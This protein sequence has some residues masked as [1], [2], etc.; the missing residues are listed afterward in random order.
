MTTDT[1]NVTTTAHSTLEPA[2]VNVRITISALWAA[3]LFVFAYVDIFSFLRSDYRADVEAG[4]AGAFSIDQTFLLL[5]TVYV[6]VPA[7]MVVAVLVLRPRANRIV[8]LVL[9]TLYALTIVGAAIGEWQYYLLGTAV[10]IVLL[11][12]IAYYAW[13]WPK[14]APPAADDRPGADR[15][16]VTAGS[17]REFPRP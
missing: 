8:N 17:A 12:A 11:A 16:E 2:P 10:E 4:K 13:T 9:S 6:V 15:P 3:M 14:V 7:L 5:T 1:L